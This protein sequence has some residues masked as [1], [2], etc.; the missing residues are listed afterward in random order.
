MKNSQKLNFLINRGFFS[1]LAIENIL[2][3]I[4]LVSH[5][6]E[7]NRRIIGIYSLPRF[8]E[9][10]SAVLLVIGAFW[11]LKELSTL[12]RQRKLTQTI[13][14]A[15]WNETLIYGGVLIAAT[16]R[17]LLIVP[18][19]LAENAELHYFTNYLHLLRPLSFYISLLGFEI[20]L[21]I[22]FVNRNRLP[23]FLG[24]KKELA[25]SLFIIW[26]ILG[27]FSIFSI[28]LSSPRA[29]TFIPYPPRIEWAFFLVW[30]LSTIAIWVIAP[31]QEEN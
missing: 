17:L 9:I 7:Q 1:L 6:S 10:C 11:S 2:A 19:F 8:L 14:S 26:G 30:I 25:I 16:G 22:L 28:F 24:I 31:S 4:I 15:P 18:Q 5:P 3:F 21:W 29:S 23:D 20:T 12:E 27:T 13:S